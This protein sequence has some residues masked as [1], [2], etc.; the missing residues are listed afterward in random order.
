MTD[1]SSELE[2]NELQLAFLSDVDVARPNFS[3]HNNFEPIAYQFE[4]TE[5]FPE[6]TEWSR[7]HPQSEGNAFQGISFT[8]DDHNKANVTITMSETN[9]GFK[10]IFGKYTVDQQGTIQSVNL[11][12]RNT[13]DVEN[14]QQYSFVHEST[15]EN[16]QFFLIANGHAYNKQLNHQ[17]SSDGSFSFVYSFGTDNERLAKVTDDPSQIDLVYKTHEEIMSLK[18]NIYHTGNQN[19][20]HDNKQHSISG[21]VSDEDTNILRIGFED[22]PNL[23][24]GDFNDLIFDVEI[25]YVPTDT[26][27]AEILN[28]TVPA[29]GLDNVTLEDINQ[30]NDFKPNHSPLSNFSTNTH[31]IDNNDR[32]TDIIEENLNTLLA[33]EK[34]IQEDNTD[35]LV[36]LDFVKETTQPSIPNQIGTAGN[37]AD[38]AI[39]GTDA[40][41]YD[42]LSI[43]T[44]IA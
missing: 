43:Y 2:V 4:Q 12:T 25:S 14:G 13:R 41:Q 33:F 32:N 21:L 5:M 9:S 16:L 18:G 15:E 6:L 31:G 17:D 19:L 7:H 44:D 23:G 8:K 42:D 29:S 38:N 36:I 30:N 34:I 22:F 40:P 35:D 28:N 37:S 10:N 20:N 11:L 27:I 24:D 1:Y 26:N 3:K 39:H